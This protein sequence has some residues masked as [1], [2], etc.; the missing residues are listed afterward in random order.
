MEINHRQF[1]DKLKFQKKEEELKKQ[2]YNLVE[3][4]DDSTLLTYEY[5]KGSWSGTQNSFE[6]IKHYTLRWCSPEN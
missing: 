5:I 3:N 6:G 4:K 1:D 2:G